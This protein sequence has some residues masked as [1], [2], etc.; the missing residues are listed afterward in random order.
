MERKDD[1][2]QRRRGA[3]LPCKT[4]RAISFVLE[5]M[6]GPDSGRAS[7]NITDEYEYECR[8]FFYAWAGLQ[9]KGQ[10]TGKTFYG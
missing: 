6:L 1:E 9:G 2:R 3:A 7:G 10:T 5:A 8:L 4:V